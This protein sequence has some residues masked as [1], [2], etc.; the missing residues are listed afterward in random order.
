MPITPTH[1][2]S[3]SGREK[4]ETCPADQQ[5]SDPA[6]SP[7]P[8]PDGQYAPRASIVCL[9]CPAGSVCDGGECHVLT[10]LL[11]VGLLTEWQESPDF[12]VINLCKVLWL[13]G[14]VS[15]SSYATLC[16]YSFPIETISFRET[17]FM[18]RSNKC[19]KPTSLH[20]ILFFMALLNLL[21]T[22]LITH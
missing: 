12:Y 17:I 19:C 10:Q 2:P 6:A 21:P 8:C 7:D 14:F 3:P 18:L 5:C 13:V 9:I 22:K 15:R 4:C 20:R 11:L 16:Y 1:C